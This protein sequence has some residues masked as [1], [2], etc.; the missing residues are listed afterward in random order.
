MSNFLGRVE[1][2]WILDKNFHTAIF[3]SVSDANFTA[4]TVNKK[5]ETIANTENRDGIRLCPL[6]ETVGERRGV[7]GMNGVR[8][9]GENDDGGVEFG[10]GLK[11]GSAVETERENGEAS[12]STSDEMSV[13][14][15]EVEDEN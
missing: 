4:E 13:L 1:S 10:D 15:T 12:D 6:E 8:T 7:W 2:R 14:R 11:G 3:L 9:T 5:L